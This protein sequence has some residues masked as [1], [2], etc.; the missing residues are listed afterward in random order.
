[1]KRTLDKILLAGFCIIPFVL[2]VVDLLF[3]RL[4]ANPIEKMLHVTGDWALNLLLAALAITP[5]VRY[6][7]W[8]RLQTLRR[9]LGL[10]AAFYALLHVSVYAGLDKAFSWTDI[11]NDAGK[12]RRIWFGAA[13]FIIMLPLAA[14]SSNRMMGLLGG[15]QWQ[16][17]HRL[18]YVAALFGVTHYLLLVKKDLRLPLWYGAAYLFLMSFRVI[19]LIRPLCKRSNPL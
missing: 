19:E 10:F 11:L 18:I 16:K 4:G 1:M 12:H 2:L 8:A 5:L 15:R 17:L 9:Q 14:T 13:A 6:A 3:N 7:G